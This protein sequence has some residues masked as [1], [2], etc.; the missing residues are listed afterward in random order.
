[1]KSAL[2]RVETALELILARTRPL[3][4]SESRP[5]L[6]SLGYIL[7]EDQYSAIDV[8][9]CDNSAMDGYALRYSDLVT[10]RAGDG[11]LPVGQRIAAG[12]MGEPLRA[13]TAA[14]IFTGAAIPPMADTVVMQ[15]NTELC[16]DT[17]RI[18]GDVKA[19]QNIRPQGQ[20]IASGSMVLSRGRCLQ[21]QD[22][23][24]LA[25]IG[26]THVEVFRPLKVA[27]MSTGDELVE[28]GQPLAAGQIYNSNRYTLSALLMALGCEVIDGGI[29]VDDFSATCQQLETL[30]GQAD[31][32]VS[33]GGVSVGEED[34]V[35]AAVEALGELALW[36][37]NIKP[38]KPLAFGHV[39][40]TPFFGLPGNPASVFVTFCLLARPYILAS[41]G[42]ASVLPLAITAVSSFS[43]QRAGT[44]QEYLR[45]KVTHRQGQPIVERYAN[46]SSGV[47]LSTSWANALAIIPPGK[48]IAEGDL[49]EVLLM[50]ELLH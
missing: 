3:V 36:K 21:P 18:L 48:I 33:S 10:A 23:G 4:S 19:G 42:R 31:V 38:G 1:M 39:K 11:V 22:I 2:M 20:D 12:S 49:V 14:R 37:L 30:A 27:V 5:L 7:A 24:L 45:A 26:L 9:P 44:R 28:P 50:S 34:Y 35:K 43:S 46:Q 15:E 41:M 47:L 16:G 32:I 6:Q 17:V 29:V 40:E 13:G 8:P 25:S